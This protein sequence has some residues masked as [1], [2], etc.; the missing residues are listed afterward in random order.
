MVSVAAI[1][2]CWI[3]QVH[4]DS[5]K[6]SMTNIILPLIILCIYGNWKYKLPNVYCLHIILHAGII[7][8]IIFLKHELLMLQAQPSNSMEWHPQ[9]EGYCAHKLRRNGQGYKWDLRIRPSQDLPLINCFY[10]HII[11]YASLHILIWNWYLRISGSEHYNIISWNW[12][13]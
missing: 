1:E 7:E 12:K 3:L 9:N 11:R 5:T 6:K 13:S 4:S 2:L 10:L 8:L